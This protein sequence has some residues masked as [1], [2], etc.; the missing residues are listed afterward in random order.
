MPHKTIWILLA[1][2]LNGCSGV[3]MVNLANQVY[4]AQIERDIAY[5]D[6]PRQK[7]DLYFPKI[8][9]AGEPTPVVVF[10]YGGTWREGSR[11]EYE[12]VGRR[13]AAMGYIVAIPDYRLY[14]EVAYPDF[15]YDSAAALPVL[16]QQLQQPRY[17]AW[18]PAKHLILMGHSAGAYNAMMLALDDRWLSA[19][20]LDRLA[21]VK[22]VIGIAGPYNFYPIVLEDAKPVFFH[23]NYPPESLPI[24]FVAA[25][26]PPVRLLKPENDTTVNPKTNTVALY[27]ALKQVGADVEMQT[28]ANSNHVTI[29]GAMSWLVFFSGDTAG[30][31]Q[32]YIEALPA[33]DP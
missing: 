9:R 11:A 25:D 29:I 8:E 10:Y 27:E 20:G 12:F 33:A 3:Q 23:P 17:A 2:L 28:I 32:G 15:L 22:A 24:D 7:L 6:N 18:H 1:G 26:A 30:A 16:Q 21:T 14:P 31:V 13:L 4:P 19:A 5:G